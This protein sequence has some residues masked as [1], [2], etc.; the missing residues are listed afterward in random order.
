M[1]DKVKVAENDPVREKLIEL[2]QSAVNGCA[3]YWAGLIAD[4][5]IAHG[6]TI[7]KDNNVPG[8]WIPVTERLPEENGYYLCCVKSFCFSGRTYINILK[9]D[10]DGFME[11]H[12]YTDDVTH[13]MPLPEPPKGE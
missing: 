7:G 6:V 12:I 5:L 4:H 3:T 9:C 2:I 13:W 8:K 11:G 1:A 10:K